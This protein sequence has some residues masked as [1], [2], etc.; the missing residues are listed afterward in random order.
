[1]KESHRSCASMN[2]Q[3]YPPTLLCPAAYLTHLLLYH[4]RYVHVKHAPG[5]LTRSGPACMST[6]RSSTQRPCQRFEP[7]GMARC[8]SHGTHTETAT[9]NHKL[10]IAFVHQ[11]YRLRAPNLCSQDIFCDIEERHVECFCFA[12]K[13]Q[14]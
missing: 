10:H 11:Y 6:T 5:I 12:F 2:L 8:F 4:C 1:M 14:L 13:V 7:S 9:S 3:P